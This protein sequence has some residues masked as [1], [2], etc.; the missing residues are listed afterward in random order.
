MQGQWAPGLQ[1]GAPVWGSNPYTDDSELRIAAVHAGLVAPGQ[2]SVVVARYLSGGPFCFPSVLSNGIQSRAWP[3][4]ALCVVL[5]PTDRVR[6]QRR[7][8][9]SQTIAVEPER[10]PTETPVPRGPAGSQR[11]DVQA[12]GRVRRQ[13]GRNVG[14]GVTS[15]QGREVQRKSVQPTKHRPPAA[16]KPAPGKSG[17]KHV[18][19]T[20]P[21]RTPGPDAAN[22]PRPAMGAHGETADSKAA[23]RGSNGRCL[24]PSPPRSRPTRPHQLSELVVSDNWENLQRQQYL[25]FLSETFDSWP[26]AA[27]LQGGD[28]YGSEAEETG[29]SGPESEGDSDASFSRLL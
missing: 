1:A 9:R 24:T 7:C 29:N 23:I 20:K 11:R 17:Q 21:S 16:A 28:R 22:P 25:S 12:S 8:T 3:S 19:G 15:A 10:A 5:L 18:R 2:H 27:P 4:M 26:C 13:G 14:K 6:S